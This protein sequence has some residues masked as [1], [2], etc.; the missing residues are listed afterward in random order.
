MRTC[1]K[2]SGIILNKMQ[3]TSKQALIDMLR[4]V[5]SQTAFIIKT[6]VRISN[7]QDF[8]NSERWH[9]IIQ[10]DVYVPANYW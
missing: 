3:S 8:L 9:G 4:F 1:A 7:Y 2:C 6:T 5:E 10:F